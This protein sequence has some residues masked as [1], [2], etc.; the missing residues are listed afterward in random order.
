MADEVKLSRKEVQSYLDLNRR[1]L[2]AQRQVDNL[3]KELQPYKTKFTAYLQQEAELVDGQR[4]LTKFGA[5]LRLKQVAGSVRWKD[6]F[7]AECGAERALELQKAV[8][9]SE[10]LEVTAVP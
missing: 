6:A 4:S 7:V 2:D 10:R 5:I 9:P 8:T 3:E 1:R